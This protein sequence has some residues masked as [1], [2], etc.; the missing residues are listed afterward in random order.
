[1]GT[2][3][4]SPWYGGVAPLFLLAVVVILLSFPFRWLVAY[5]ALVRGRSAVVWSLL[6]YVLGP[7]ALVIA[8]LP[9]APGAVPPDKPGSASLV[10]EVLTTLGTCMAAG[11]LAG[12]LLF[13]GAALHATPTPTAQPAARPASEPRTT[14]AEQRIKELREQAER[15]GR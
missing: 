5:C 4:W 10:V 13:T 14:G 2:P 11:L 3:T 6:T 7:F 1:M 15:A 12:V 9:S 8:V